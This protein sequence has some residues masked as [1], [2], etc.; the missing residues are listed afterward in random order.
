MLR[1]QRDL[2]AKPGRRRTVGSLVS[3]GALLIGIANGSFFLLV[4]GAAGLVVDA[5][6]YGHAW[7]RTRDAGRVDLELE[8]KARLA[9]SAFVAFVLG[10]TGVLALTVGA[11]TSRGWGGVM[12]GA[13][14]LYGGLG[15]AGYRARLRAAGDAVA[16]LPAD[17]G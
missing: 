15:V 4:I 13:G 8:G 5:V 16:K 1:P 7:L 9:G 17:R 6:L 2:A 10:L 12:L 3:A 11:E 14:A